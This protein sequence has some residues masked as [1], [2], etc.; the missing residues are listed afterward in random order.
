MQKVTEI[1]EWTVVAILPNEQSPMANHLGGEVAVDEDAKRFYI[2]EV[3]LVCN[4]LDSVT[5]ACHGYLANT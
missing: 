3:F 1:N 2:H 4:G 5:K